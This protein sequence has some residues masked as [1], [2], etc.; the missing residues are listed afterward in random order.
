[1]IGGKAPFMPEEFIVDP[2]VRLRRRR[3][4]AGLITGLFPRWR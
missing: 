4:D 1:L 3:E 2:P